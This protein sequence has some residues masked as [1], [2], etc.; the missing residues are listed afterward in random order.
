LKHYKH[1]ASLHRTSVQTD[2]LEHDFVDCE[3]CFKYTGRQYST[4]QDI[5]STHPHIHQRHSHL[6]P[7][8]AQYTLII[9]LVTYLLIEMRCVTRNLT[10]FSLY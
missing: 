2:L 3:S 6:L 4:P 5:L 10:V 1:V 7:T 9:N 8:A